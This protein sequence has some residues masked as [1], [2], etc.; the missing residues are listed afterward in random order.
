VF[1]RVLADE[2]FRPGFD[3]LYDRT[4]IRDLPD[5][6]FLRSWPSRQA[7]LL[8]ESGGGWLAAIVASEP[9]YVLFRT[10]GA[11][12]DELGASAEVFW[13]EDDA[14]RWLES[15]ANTA[16]RDAMS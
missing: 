2:R 7:R 5:M 15:K 1:A 13:T 16:E 4:R 10:A 9:V 11:C 8:R 14:L 12:I 6:A 3:F